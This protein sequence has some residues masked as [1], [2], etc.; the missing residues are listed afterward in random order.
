M[1]FGMMIVIAI[2]IGIVG[3]F[4]GAGILKAQLNSVHRQTAA[5]NYIRRDSFVLTEKNDR[6]L[7]RKVDKTARPKD[8][9]K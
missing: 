2:V 5:S 9:R 6:F 3:G 1:D 4:V 8:N 7:Y